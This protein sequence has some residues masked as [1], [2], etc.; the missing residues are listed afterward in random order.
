MRRVIVV[1]SVLV[2]VVSGWLHSPQ[3]AHAGSCGGG[4][5]YYLPIFGGGSMA[6]ISASE[7][8]EKLVRTKGDFPFD[9]W[10]TEIQKET[11]SVKL[12]S[13][14]QVKRN[15]RIPDHIKGSAALVKG[16][17]VRLGQ[18]QGEPI[19]LAILPQ[20]TSD[21]NYAGK[22]SIIPSP[23]NLVVVATRNGW[24]AT[25]TAAAGADRYH[26]Y[27]NDTADETSPDDM[28]YVTGTTLTVPYE[29]PYIYFAIKSVSGLNESELS[30]WCTDETGPPEPNTFVALNNINGH[31]LFVASNDIALTDPGF[32]Y[33]E[34]E[35]ALDGSGTGAIDLGDF[36]LGDFPSLQS[37]GRETVRYYRIRSVDWAGNASDWTDW[38]YAYAGQSEIQDKFDG[39]GG[40]ATSSLESLYWLWVASA[41]SGE[42]FWS[43]STNSMTY[44]TTYKVEGA[45]SIRIQD[46]SSLGNWGS[47]SRTYSPTIDLTAEGRFTDGD[48]L[49]V[50]LYLPDLTYI[51]TIRLSFSYGGG[52]YYYYDF[53]SSSLS[54]GW[55]HLKV[56][57]SDFSNS[58]GT[59][60]W[61]TIYNV[62]IWS[63]RQGAGYPYIYFDDIRLVKADP[64]ASTAYNDTGNSWDKAA[65]T[66]TDTGEWHVYPGNRSGEPGKPFSYGQIKTAASPSLWYLSHKPLT[67]TDIASGTIQ[68]GVYLKGADGKAGLSFFVKDVTAASWDMYAIEADS[69]ADTI[70]LVKWVGGTRTVIASASFTF[71]YD[72]ILWLGADFRDY[73]ADGGRIRVYASL[74][75]GNLI[76]ATNMLI[77]EQDTEWTGEAGG[78]VGVMSYQANVRFVNFVAGSPAH[79]DVAD[80][81]L[82]LDGPIMAGETR[83]IRPNRD[84]CNFEYS[85]DG[86]TWTPFGILLGEIKMWATD[87]APAGWLL[88]YGQAISRTTYAALYAVIGTTFGT[89]DGSTTFNLPDFRG[90]M[91]MGQDDMGGTSANRVTAVAADSIG[92][93]GGAETHTLT[94]TE[95]PAHTHNMLS[96]T[97]GLYWVGAQGDGKLDASYPTSSVGG[98]GAHN[99]MPP[100]L[101]LNFIIYTGV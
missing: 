101:A 35:Q 47:I 8:I 73:D 33:F 44:D 55:N 36:T 93:S 78:N 62:G 25:W 70:T 100:Y 80:V 20:F 12:V 22:G 83:R 69:S 27:R 75:E 66:G 90:R 57:R 15:V 81:A 19:L 48:Y 91:P 5:H 65:S 79:A 68:A 53:L 4:N 43:D 72:Q 77:S 95:M 52:N 42:A 10:V 63:K 16:V 98:N 54:T 99:N 37:F 58:G 40:S 18:L 13:T 41:E 30:A 96:P 7:S 6:N 9:G 84:T 56:M 2:L 92:G 11:A 3:Q 38:D 23:P 29:S 61:A 45:S 32:Y 59:P 82:A 31:S 49:I 17:P 50:S 51:D 74:S 39:Y 24:Q 94:V 34:I 88:C 1:I 21:V 97:G 87:T 26:V 71:T 85:D 60:S 76:Q 89:G 64:D 28:G 86:S 46:H 67:T 14:E